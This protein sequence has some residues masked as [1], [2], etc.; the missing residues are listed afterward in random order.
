MSGDTLAFVNQA[1][2]TANAYDS[3]HGILTLVGARRRST[4]RL[5]CGR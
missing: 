3:M 2:I 4:T 5:P 1:G